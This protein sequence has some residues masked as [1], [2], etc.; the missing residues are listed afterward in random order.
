ML[1][2]ACLCMISALGS[3]VGPAAQAGLP[4]LVRTP[5]ELKKG[6]LLFGALWGAMLAIGAGL[7]GLFASAFGRDAAFVANA[8]SFAIACLFVTL[9]KRPMQESRARRP[10]SCDSACDRSPT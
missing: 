2:F 6:S 1:G 10:T 8:L 7:G 4:N 3:F 5:E 9:I